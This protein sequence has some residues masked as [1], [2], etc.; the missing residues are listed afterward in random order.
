[1]GNAMESFRIEDMIEYSSEKRVR[2]KLLQCDGLVS[3]MVCYEPGQETVPHHHPRQDEIFYI[4]E[5]QGTITIGDES[6]EVSA[7]SVVFAPRDIPHAIAAAPDSRLVILF[8]KGP[9]KLPHPSAG[10]A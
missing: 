4:V 7:T 6:V 8:F 10:S 3:E 1:M 2:K 9:G 5:G